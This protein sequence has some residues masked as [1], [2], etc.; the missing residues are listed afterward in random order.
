MV[1]EV[2]TLIENNETIESLLGTGHPVDSN[3]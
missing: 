1:H 2:A 3:D